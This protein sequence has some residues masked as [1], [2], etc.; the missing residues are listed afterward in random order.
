MEIIDLNHT[1]EINK[2]DIAICLGNFD[3]LHLAHQKLIKKTVEYAN[4]EKLKSAILI[5]ENHTK[6]I[7][8]SKRPKL[9]MSYDNK[10]ETLK[11]LGIDI[12][13]K[14]K[15]S[16]NLMKLSPDDFITSILIDKLNASAIIVGF[17][18][19]FGYKASGDISKLIEISK[20][21]N[22][23]VIVIDPI[24]YSCQL[25]NILVSSTEIRNLLL[26]GNLRLANKLL[27]RNFSIEG[28][29]VHGSKRGRVMGFPTANIEVDSSM[30]IPK[31][32]I[33]ATK[34]HVNEKTYL[35]AT[36]VGKNL[37]FNGD[38]IKIETFI[39]DF[40]ENIY[41]EIIELEFL[42]YIRDEIKFD[43]VE[44][45]VNKINEDVDLIKTI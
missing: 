27:G 8:S 7:T 26:N 5:F 1:I 44:E 10:I 33:Y 21:N 32:G 41:D 12:I 36:S 9:L 15:F 24:I 6:N 22:I 3:G 30:L 25:D 14:I 23:N 37:T 34:V 29:I 45:L 31:E 35:G 20:N 4:Q 42:E 19:K 40:N 11:K 13:Y 18:Y 28:K 16:D 38:S 43:S 2:S 39:I 17:D